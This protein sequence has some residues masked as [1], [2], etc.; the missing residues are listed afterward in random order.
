MNSKEIE[1]NINQIFENFSKEEFIFDLLMAYGIS[2]TSITRLRKGDYNLSKIEGEI[3]YKKKVFF[4]EESNDKLLSSIDTFSKEERI[5]KHNPRFVILTDYETLVAKDKKLGKSLD[6][7]IQELPKYF[8]FFLPLAGS[9]VYNTK[10]DNKA[11]REAAYKMAELYDELRTANPGIYNSKESIHEL[12]IFLSRLLFCFFAEDTGIFDEDSIFTN[13]LAQHTADNGSDTNIFLND[14]FK[15]LNTTNSDLFPGYLAKFPY[16]NGGL[17][18]DV[19]ESPQF[20]FKARKI[21]ISLG[22]LQWQEINPDIFGSMIQAVVE[23]EYRSDLG[24]HYTSVENILKLIRPLFLDELEEEFDK[25][26]DSEQ[27]LKRLIFRMSKIKFFDPA[28]GSGNFLIITYKE[29]RSL[30]IRILQRM[31][32]L[33]SNPRIVFTQIQLSQFYGIEIDDFAHEMAIL[34]L[35]L[36][37]HQMNNY[38]EEQLLDYGKSKPILPLKE[39]GKITRGNATRIDW[40]SIC[41]ITENDE[42]Y[43]I[44]NPPYYGSRKQNQDQKEDLKFVFRKNYKSLDYISAWFL[45]GAE[46]IDGRNAKYAF[47]S[48]NSICQGDQVSLT[49][50][51]IL[52]ERVEFFFAYQSFK[53]KNNAKGNAGVTVVIIGLRN[54]SGQKK[55]LYRDRFKQ[56]VKNINS[57]LVDA[58]NIIITG[59]SKPISKFPEMR[60]G[61]MPN[62]SG[63]LILTT[64]EK[65]D[66]EKKYPVSSIW[67]KSFLG[68]SEYIRGNNRFCLW[69]PDSE[70]S[71]AQLIPDLTIRLNK[72]IEHRQNSTEKS[73]R[74]K[75]KNPNH[76]YFSSHENS[77][78]ILIPRHSSETREYIPMGFFDSNT[79]I[80]D[81]AM[82]IYNAEPWIFAVITSRM[83]M[84]WVRAVGGRLKTDYRYSAKLCYNTFPFPTI[85]A[86]DKE[87]LNLY[88]F[89]IIDERAKYP[90]K[91]MA[92]LYD[93]DTMPL[94]LRK[95]HK[96]LDAAIERCYRLQPFP[97][98]TERLEYLFKLY[99]EMLQKDTLFAKQ[100]KSRTKKNKE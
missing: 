27:Q 65:K 17:F 94:G 14:L 73:T 16:V 84:V 46:Y 71:E 89:S 81:S 75:A 44:G 24:M 29:I 5:L 21:L 22:E 38:F 64:D 23:P 97:S 32:E 40:K 70:L 54:I 39:A 18:R 9:E 68:A 74:D 47:V 12:N 86:K 55:Y 78:S 53:W 52:N 4:K 80:A 91:T 87:N 66:L 2:K 51:R 20:N 92:Q 42:I 33:D 90:E 34:S 8:D 67:I 3:L 11:D 37:E 6:I 31:I 63:N 98:D 45:K 57:Y 41:P 35:W 25:H 19:I 30:E 99:E 85:S 96:E 1:H 82:A 60:Y 7:P 93:P 50:P 28:C 26:K 88:I 10:N 76:F 36:A 69:I 15:R 58:S 56:E 62:D 59:L 43:I 100:K 72:V 79:V 77:D 95:A 61:N 49:W 48:T 83:H 13:T